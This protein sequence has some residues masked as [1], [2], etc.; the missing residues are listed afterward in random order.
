MS[1]TNGTYDYTVS[2]SN[3]HYHARYSSGAVRV[4]GY[5]I[6]YLTF[7]QNQYSM[8]F[9]ESGLPGGYTWYVNVTGQSPESASSGSAINL[10]LINGSYSYTVST[11]DKEYFNSPGRGT[12][13]IDWA[14]HSNIQVNFSL[15]TDSVIFSQSTLPRGMMW[16]VNVTD[17]TGHEITNSSTTSTITFNC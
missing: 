13:S 9:T 16:Y 5:T 7:V 12:F 14:D 4:T 8:S 17:S 11:T 15:H 10:N 2:T 3:G 6:E 1:V